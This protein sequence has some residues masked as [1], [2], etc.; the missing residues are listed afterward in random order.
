M[1]AS[2]IS[3]PDK[4]TSDKIV[5]SV[6]WRVSIQLSAPKWTRKVTKMYDR[7]FGQELTPF[8]PLSVF[9]RT[10]S[11]IRSTPEC[12][13]TF[14]GAHTSAFIDPHSYSLLFLVILMLLRCLDMHLHP[15]KCQKL[16]IHH[17]SVV[18]AHPS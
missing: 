17:R 2:T 12:V 4:K 9:K 5:L 14:L 1:Y 10:G 11:H 7:A 8:R 13:F 3:S 18:T 6:P 15:L 16:H